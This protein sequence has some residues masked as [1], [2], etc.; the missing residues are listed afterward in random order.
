MTLPINV[1]VG[2]FGLRNIEVYKPVDGDAGYKKP[3][4]LGS[5]P[6]SLYVW[7]KDDK[8]ERVADAYLDHLNESEQAEQWL[9]DFAYITADG[10]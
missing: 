1:E 9:L 6:N 7:V 5:L 10:R 4:R 3:F 8:H 2:P